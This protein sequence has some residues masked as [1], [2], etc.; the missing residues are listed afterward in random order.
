MYCYVLSTRDTEVRH[1]TSPVVQ[2]LR[3]GAPNA[4]GRAQK[5]LRILKY[6]LCCSNDGYMPLYACPKPIEYTLSQLEDKLCTLGD[7]DVSV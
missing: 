4:G 2:W 3:L 6:S 1:G 5:I 7:Y